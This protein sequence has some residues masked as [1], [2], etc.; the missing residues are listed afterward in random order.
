MNSTISLIEASVS[1]DTGEPAHAGKFAGGDPD[2]QQQS[3]ATTPGEGPAGGFEAYLAA[4]RTYPANEIPPAVSAHKLLYGQ[5]PE[6]VFPVSVHNFTKQDGY[7]VEIRVFAKD[8]P[9]TPVLATSRIGSAPMEVCSPT[10]LET[11]A[12]PPRVP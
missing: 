7:P 11:N 8:K 4:E 1:G 12:K 9:G 5:A 3:S 10:R 6:I 2:Q